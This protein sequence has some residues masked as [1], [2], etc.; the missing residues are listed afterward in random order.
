ACA[1]DSPRSSSL[2]DVSEVASKWIGTHVNHPNTGQRV[3]VM[4]VRTVQHP[5]DQREIV[6]MV[7]ANGPPIFSERIGHF[8]FEDN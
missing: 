7:V 2:K 6:A 1:T 5:Q 3:R 4:D 8:V